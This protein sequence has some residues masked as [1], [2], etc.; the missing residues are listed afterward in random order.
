[1][2][3]GATFAFSLEDMGNKKIRSQENPNFGI[4]DLYI[5]RISVQSLECEKLNTFDNPTSI[6]FI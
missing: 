1:M 3:R 6:N 5:G 2:G 4:P